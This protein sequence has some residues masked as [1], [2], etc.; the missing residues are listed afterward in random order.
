MRTL[1][2]EHDES[3][4][5]PATV[6]MVYGSPE[7]LSPPQGLYLGSRPLPF[8]NSP[9]IGALNS[10]V[11]TVPVALFGTQTLVFRLSNALLLGLFFLLAFQLAQEAGGQQGGGR[12]VAWITVALLGADVELWLQ[13]LTNQGPFL[14]QLI[15]T[16]LLV[17]FFLLYRQTR[18][19]TYIAAMALAMGLGL[20]EK[21]TYLWILMLFLLAALLFYGTEFLQ[22]RSAKHL[23]LGLVCILILVIPAL[24]Y[25]LG[26][27]ATT[28]GFAASQ[29]AWPASIQTVA[30]QRFHNLN[31]LFG[32]QWTMS[33]RAGNFLALGVDRFSPALALIGIGFAVAL[34]RRQRFP[35]F[36][37]S[38]ACGLLALNLLFPEG[39]RLHHLILMYP[40][41]QLAAAI[42]LWSL[43]ERSR[44]GQIALI[45]LLCAGQL[46]S[47]RNILAFNQ[48]VSASGG[49]GTWS[50]QI[51]K[52][53]DWEQAHPHLHLVYAC[54]GIEHAIF[55]RNRGLRPHKDFYF[56]LSSDPLSPETKSELDQSLLRRDTVWIS[57]SVEDLQRK[58][59]SNLFRY[60]AQKGL[61]PIIVK[62]FR[63]DSS[64][65]V[66]FTAISFQPLE[67]E[68]SLP[69]APVWNA[70]DLKTLE[71]NLSPGFDRLQV[72]LE[73]SG[74]Q[75]KDSIW[76]EFQAPGGEIVQ[77]HFR[78]LQYFALTD[79]RLRWVF[80]RNLYPD[81]F[82]SDFPNPHLQPQKLVIRLDSSN[83]AASLRPS[84]S[85][86]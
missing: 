79:R 9:Y 64:N 63:G 5:W 66:L 30:T 4:Y 48:A 82:L 74:L 71:A 17:R 2:P 81:W 3:L 72:D 61:A 14:L 85:R 47:F 22:K 68:P 25:L 12:V 44:L 18:N 56:P 38:I 13:G 46:S 39:G 75:A 32:G 78:P 7:R 19:A 21:L 51:S 83:P 31:L 50:Q 1:G 6:R 28:S 42:S 43:L 76:V 40:L 70:V 26:N 49:S 80:G 16:S 41:P 29:F 86:P 59:S 57:S 11:Y 10:Y 8:M 34:L 36:C 55:T 67:A 54:W 60:A 33:H 73:F 53:A 24:T 20:N 62:E 37:Y 69:V 23:G 27:Y 58:A 35:L 65:R 15:A 45:S 84:I 77:R 52:L